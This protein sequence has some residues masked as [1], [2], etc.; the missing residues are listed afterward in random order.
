MDSKSILLVIGVFMLIAAAFFGSNAS[1]YSEPV[2]RAGATFGFALAGGLSL[3]ASAI[4]T[5]KERP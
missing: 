4:A 5:T 1:I 2:V 3:L